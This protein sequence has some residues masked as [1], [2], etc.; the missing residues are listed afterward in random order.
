MKIQ[1]EAA[2]KIQI[3]AGTFEIKMAVR[4][5]IICFVSDKDLCRG[6]LCAAVYKRLSVQHRN[7][8]TLD[9][10][11]EVV[12][13]GVSACD[14][15]EI[16]SAA[17]EVLIESGYLAQDDHERHYSRKADRLLM[18]SCRFAVAADNDIAMSLMLSFPESAS[19]I[20]CFC[21]G[22]RPAEHETIE[23]Y[24]RVLNDAEDRLR[25]MFCFDNE[26]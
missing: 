21:E 24:R 1:A 7:N 13:C 18:E 17:A 6:P 25:K 16:S 20:K 19:K 3:E 23:E 22:I 12:S 4:P 9:H 5:D 10:P 15:Q 2:E 11:L 26:H 8:E 14:G